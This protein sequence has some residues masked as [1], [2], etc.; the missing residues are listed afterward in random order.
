M[1]KD[2]RKILWT[3]I[4]DFRTNPFDSLTEGHMKFNIRRRDQMKKAVIVLILLLLASRE[5]ATARA[6]DPKYSPLSEYRM[7]RDAEIA[8]ARSAQPCPGCRPWT[9][10]RILSQWNTSLLAHIVGKRFRW[11]STCRFAVKYMSK[12][13]KSAVIQSRSLTVCKM[14][15][16]L[17]FMPRSSN[18]FA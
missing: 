2:K 14:M 16:S 10:C 8:L 13:A 12:T 11:F 9:C 4:V 6:Q 18:K 7:P 1:I 3:R 5:P 17:A 15:R